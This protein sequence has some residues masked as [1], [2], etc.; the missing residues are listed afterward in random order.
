MKEDPVLDQFVREV[1]RPLADRLAPMM[2]L[3]DRIP[4]VAVARGIP[5]RLGTTKEVLMRPQE[6]SEADYPEFLGQDQEIQSAG[7]YASPAT[8]YDVAAMMRLVAALGAMRRANPGIDV[9]LSRLAVNPGLFD[10]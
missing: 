7:Y 4:A 10:K 3:L 5:E 6:W 9:L 1:L 8:V 2:P